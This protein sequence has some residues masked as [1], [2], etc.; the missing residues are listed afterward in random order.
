M[1]P[2]SYRVSVLIR[3]DTRELALSLTVTV[4]VSILHTIQMSTQREGSHLQASLLYSKRSH[5]KTN[6][7]ITLI[8]D[9]QPPEL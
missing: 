4:R 3:R 2:Q 6:L 7:A 8:F 1:G 5:T 9:F